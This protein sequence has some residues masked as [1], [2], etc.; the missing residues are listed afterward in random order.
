MSEKVSDYFSS[1]W[2]VS[3]L[4]L[5]ITYFI[6]IPLSY[7][8][9]LHSSIAMKA[10]QCN[11]ILFTMIKATYFLRMFDGFS[12]LIQMIRS[13]LLDLKYFLLFFAIFIGSVSFF[14]MILLPNS[15]EGLDE[16]YSGI[17]PLAYYTMALR[18]AIG[19]NEMSQYLSGYESGGESHLTLVWIIWLF[20]VIIGNIV[21]MNF[22][23]AV[24]N[25]SYENCMTK[26][27][28]QTYKVKVDMIVE[29]EQ[30]MSESDL[31]N[32]QW[33]PSFIISRQLA[34]N[35]GAD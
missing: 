7:L 1:L 2:N 20:I 21:F 30:M 24:V 12:F 13:V 27:V 31:A 11:I 5:M 17:S 28:A 25:E 18:T 19:D 10:I 6:Y 15:H 9:T 14:L 22:I 4:T 34:N 16:A 35:S 29:R 3:D 26:L 32:K 8:P 33:F 23:I